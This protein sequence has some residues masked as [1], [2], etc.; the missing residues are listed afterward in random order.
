MDA[1]TRL[2]ENVTK[3][4]SKKDYSHLEDVC[5]SHCE[6]LADRNR[7]YLAIPYE[8]CGSQPLSIENYQNYQRQNSKINQTK[9]SYQDTDEDF[10]ST[11]DTPVDKIKRKK[12][13]RKRRSRLTDIDSPAL[14]ALEL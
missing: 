12:R 13:R 6:G 10:S 9:D 5:F 7:V 2:L 11:E 1:L 3:Y 8:D 4:L 14:F